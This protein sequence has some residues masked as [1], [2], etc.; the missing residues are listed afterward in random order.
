MLKENGYRTA[1]VGKWHLGMNFA[2]EEGFVEKPDFGV[3]DHVDYH[4][5]IE[6]SP[7]SNGFEYFT[8]LADLWTCRH[9]SILKMIILQRSRIM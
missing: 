8:A 6:G 3:C 4:G 2:K 1:M 7:I 9:I 5:K